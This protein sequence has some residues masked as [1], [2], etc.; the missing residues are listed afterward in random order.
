MYKDIRNMLIAELKQLDMILIEKGVCQNGR[1]DLYQ[2]YDLF[3]DCT[4]GVLVGSSEVRIV[5]YNNQYELTEDNLIFRDVF[6]FSYMYELMSFG[7]SMK[8]IVTEIILIL[9]EELEAYTNGEIQA[10]D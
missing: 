4:L 8:T 1:Y 5:L 10:G 3:T 9:I 6:R 7:N 2:S